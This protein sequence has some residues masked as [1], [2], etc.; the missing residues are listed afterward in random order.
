MNFR[1]SICSPKILFQWIF[2]QIIWLWKFSYYSSLVSIAERMI[3][4]TNL[5]KKS[6]IYIYLYFKM[7]LG[8]KD[9]RTFVRWLQV[10][11]Y[12]LLFLW[13]Y[14]MTHILSLYIIYRFWRASEG[15]FKEIINKL[16][17][18]FPVHV[19]NVWYHNIRMITKIHKIS[20]SS[21]I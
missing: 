4:D 18:T 15:L 21:F 10:N 2:G 9:W 20:Y 7:S 1:I 12:D 17:T 16:P 6:Y 11:K 14:D 13:L 8:V 19:R 3:F 5:R